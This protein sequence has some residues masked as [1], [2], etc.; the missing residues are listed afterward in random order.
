MASSLRQWFD[1]YHAN[2]TSDEKPTIEISFLVRAVYLAARCWMGRGRKNGEV[3]QQE[4]LEYLNERDVDKNTVFPYD[5][6]RFSFLRELAAST[7]TAVSR[8]R[9]LMIRINKDDST[10]VADGMP[11]YVFFELRHCVNAVFSNPTVV[12]AGAPSGSLKGGLVFCG[13]P[14]HRYN[15]EGVPLDPPDGMIYIAYVNKSRFLF[16]WDWGPE[17]PQHTGYPVGWQTRFNGPLSQQPEATLPLPPNLSPSVFNA[18]NVWYSKE[19][20]CIFWYSSDDPAFAERVNDDL[21]LF[22]SLSDRRTIVGAKLKNIE[23]ILAMRKISREQLQTKPLMV[24][25]AESLAYQAEKG[26][27]IGHYDELISQV[28]RHPLCARAIT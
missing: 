21:T 15:N 4:L 5:Q 14:A 1:R 13:R 2:L 24:I 18:N 26:Q 19:G 23:R 22:K 16:D 20:D 10:A 25:I 11:A 28:Q 3:W 12:F 7:G 9:P 27:P 6:A 8:S 17:D